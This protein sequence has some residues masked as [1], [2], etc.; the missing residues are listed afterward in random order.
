MRGFCCKT[1]H[2]ALFGTIGAMSVVAHVAVLALFL[3]FA[4]V[5]L[6]GGAITAFEIGQT[7]A[8]LMAMSF[9]FVLNNA[10]TY[11]DKRLTGAAALIKGWIKFGLKCSVGLL[12]NVA[13]AAEL[14]RFGFHPY[15]AGLT[16]IIIGSVWSLALSSRVVWGRYGN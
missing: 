1:P 13:V 6:Q 14:V 11:A 2:R 3:R 9:N 15:A 8:A 16:G 7:L 10:L 12:A 4:G 5:S